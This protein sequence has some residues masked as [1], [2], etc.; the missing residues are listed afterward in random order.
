[1]SD[2]TEVERVAA[3]TFRAIRARARLEHGGNTQA[4]LVVYAVESFLRRL[5][6]SAYADKMVLKGGMLLAANRVRRVTRDADLSTHGLRNDENSLRDIVA[7]IA[8]LTPSP[9]DGVVFDPSSIRSEIMRAEDEYRG[10]RC[11]LVARLAQARMPFALDFSFGDAGRSTVIELDSIV[12]RPTI[13]LHAY[14]LTLN[15]AE[16]IVTAMEC[17]ETNPRDRDFAD[18][19]VT[20]RVHR[21]DGAE[22]R[23]DITQVASARGQRLTSFAGALAE[24]PNRQQSYDAMVERMSYLQPPPVGWDELIAD[25]VAFVDPLLATDASAQLYWDPRLRRWGH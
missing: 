7:A 17:R 11:D 14:P 16:K 21:I 5:A 6:R 15:L 19:W 13:R 2:P 20:S 9:H 25:V 3:A 12:D 4:L 18:I 22:L 10:I 1:M 24:I 8:T 23:N